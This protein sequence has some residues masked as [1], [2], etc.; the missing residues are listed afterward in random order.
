MSFSKYFIISFAE[1]AVY[2][3]VCVYPL[4]NG[5]T[6]QI[7]LLLRAS[8]S[9]FP[10]IRVASSLIQMH[11]GKFLSIRNCLSLYDINDILLPQHYLY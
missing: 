10:V 3:F 5:S 1:L 9:T 2:E 6:N 8:Y 7:I 4:T 11:N